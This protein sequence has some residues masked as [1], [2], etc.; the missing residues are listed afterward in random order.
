MSG[1]NWIINDVKKVGAKL[2]FQNGKH[3]ITLSKA[4]TYNFLT[5]YIF[6]IWLMTMV[7]L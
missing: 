3:R 5:G 1:F 2:E 4:G 6:D 7:P